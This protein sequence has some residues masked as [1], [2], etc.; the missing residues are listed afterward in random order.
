MRIICVSDSRMNIIEQ[1]VRAA[2]ATV[3]NAYEYSGRDTRNTRDLIDLFVVLFFRENTWWGAAK[4]HWLPAQYEDNI[5]LPKGW[6]P[7][8]RVNGH[9]L[10][11]VREVSNRI[12][13]T[14]S[15]ESD[16]LYIH[17]VTIFGHNGINCD[18]TCERAEQCFPIETPKTDP[19]FTKNSCMPFFHSAPAC[20]SGNKGHI[21]GA[22][23]ELLPFRQMAANVCATR[24]HTTGDSSAEEVPCF[25]AALAKLNPHW[26]KERLYQEARKIMGGYFQV[27]TFRDY[28][29]HIVGPDFI[30]RQLST[31]PGYD[32]SIDP[33]ISNVFATAAYR[34]AHLM[35]Q[36]LSQLLHKVFF[37]PWR[38]IF[39]DNILGLVG[40]PAKLN[41][42]NKMMP[43]D[44]R[45]RLFKFSTQ[46]AL[47]LASLNMQRGRDHGLPGYNQWFRFCGLS[48]P[49]TLAELSVVMNNTELA[50]KLLDLY[51]TPDNIDVWLGGWWENEE[52]FKYNQRKPEGNFTCSHQLAQSFLIS[53]KRVMWIN[54]CLNFD[55]YPVIGLENDLILTMRQLS[56]LV[57]FAKFKHSS[58]CNTFTFFDVFFCKLV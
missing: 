15:V 44:L 52:V 21:F 20:G 46:L 50:Q 4:T 18:K 22:I 6:S 40:R 35:V 42:Q 49:K 13:Q 36:P 55:F 25:V 24:R 58:G 47:D 43:D 11:L 7:E 53:F 2:K 51:G 37:T 48:E 34:F 33:S 10:P 54:L 12:M 5:S 32:E 45:E 56:G 39:E 26:D 23:R 57:E 16:P 14:A 31:Y 28:L 41:T 29:Y 9:L 30:Q 27:I 3:D 38:I 17:L 8:L 1:A 19:R